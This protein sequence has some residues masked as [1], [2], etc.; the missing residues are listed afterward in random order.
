M[1]Y[2]SRIRIISSHAPFGIQR[3]VSFHHTAPCNASCFGSF[4]ARSGLPV[5]PGELVIASSESFRGLRKVDMNGSIQQG[6]LTVI[7]LMIRSL[8]ELS[9]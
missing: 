6:S 3:P 5:V 9:G 2:W 8:L 4:L 7:F 1:S